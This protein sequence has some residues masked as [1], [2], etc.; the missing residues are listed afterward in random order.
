MA[1]V[2]TLPYYPK[3]NPGRAKL[4]AILSRTADGIIR[5]QDRKSGLWYQVLDKP[6]EKGNYLESSASGMFIYALAKGVRLGYL[7]KHYSANAQ[8]GWKGML[9]HFVET[10]P[11]GSITITS[12]VKSIDLG[13]APS[14]DGSYAYYTSAPVINNDPKG[15]GAFLLASTEIEL[16]TAKE[17]GR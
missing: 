16:I 1:L 12:T 13:S 5:H 11:D 9:D 7:P 15:V 2:D 10:A 14:H 17:K 6:N 3:G 8:R 4:L